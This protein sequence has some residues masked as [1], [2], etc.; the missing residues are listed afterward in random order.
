MPSH[1]QRVLFLCTGNSARS[2]LAEALLNHHAGD[3][4]EAYSAG[5]HPESVHPLTIVAL[6]THGIEG[7]R[8]SKHIDE[9]AGLH[10]DYIITLC[11]KATQECKA[12]GTHEKKLE[13]SFI[14]PKVSNLDGLSDIERFQATLS[15]IYRRIQSFILIEQGELLETYTNA[16]SITPLQVFKSL[17]DELRLVC[18][19]LIQ[20]EGELCVCELMEALED[21]QPKVSRHLALLKKSGLLID[22]RLGQWIF[23]RINPDLPSWA[24]AILAQTCDAN[25]ERY[26]ENIKRLNAMGDRPARSKACCSI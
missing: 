21:Q 17:S 24:K 20:Y 2:Q 26:S 22:R 15:E 10:F 23:Y 13:W 16:D 25:I 1:K 7:S 12:L 5:T 6:K 4:F 8:R 14:D 9:L 18:L 11:D 3:R 19:M